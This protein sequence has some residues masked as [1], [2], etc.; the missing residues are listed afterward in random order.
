LAFTVADGG[1]LGCAKSGT[2]GFALGP[3]DP[4][5]ECDVGRGA[6]GADVERRRQE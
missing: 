1:A 3:G 6:S 2:R 5:T 4:Y